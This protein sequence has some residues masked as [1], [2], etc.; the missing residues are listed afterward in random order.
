M[1]QA[2]FTI[3]LQ[4]IDIKTCGE[5]R[6]LV[7]S[8]TIPSIIFQLIPFIQH[9][10]LRKTLTHSLL[11]LQPK[12]HLWIGVWPPK[13]W[14]VCMHICFHHLALQTINHTPCVLLQ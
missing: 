7:L 12:M 8:L 14:T 9:S 5:Y 1:G 10:T 6:S 2:N 11:T 3:T 4:L 13:G